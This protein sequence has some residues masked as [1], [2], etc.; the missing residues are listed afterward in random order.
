M[1]LGPVARL[2]P[3]CLR[4]QD[5][6]S[7]RLDLAS[8]WGSD[9]WNRVS[10]MSWLGEALVAQVRNPTSVFNAQPGGQSSAFTGLPGTPPEFDAVRFSFPSADLFF[11]DW[12]LLRSRVLQLFAVGDAV[13]VLGWLF[14]FYLFSSTKPFVL[15]RRRFSS[16][17]HE[18]LLSS[19]SFSLHHFCSF[20]RTLFKPHFVVAHF[21]HHRH[22]TLQTES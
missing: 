20:S 7:P 22:Q 10:R 21:T 3:L 16:T 2:F 11:P 6:A 13:D 14:L 8:R 19:S 1:E 4:A 15:L 9:G 5:S 17:V 12:R 18:R